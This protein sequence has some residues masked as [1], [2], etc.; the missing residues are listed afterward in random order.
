[1]KR[2][3]NVMTATS[4]ALYIVPPFAAQAQDYP[5]AMVGDVQVICLPDDQ[6][7]CPDGAT[8]AI[9][10]SP[11]SCQADAEQTLGAQTGADQAAV[12]QAAADQAAAD[13]AAADQAAADQ[14]A[15]DQAAADQAAAD[16][17]A[18]DQAAADQAA[19]DQAAADQAAA[20]Q[21][22]AD[23]AA[24]D[25]AAADQA[26]ADQAASAPPELQT[27]N[28]GDVEVI[29]LP[30]A[31]TSCPD[32][33]VC[34]VLTAPDSCQADA[35]KMISDQAAADKA[36]SDQAAADQAAADQAAADQAAADKAA[37]DQAAA[38]QAA[39]DQ[40]AADKAASDQAAADKA[41]SDQAAADQAAAD[42][43]ASD[44]AAAQ[45]V[46]GPQIATVG[47]AQVV[48][49]PDAQTPCPDGAL[50][51]VLTSPD[52]CQADAEQAVAAQTDAAQQQAAGDQAAATEAAA[53][54]AQAIAAAEEAQKQAE[55][56]AAADPNIVPIEAPVPDPEAVNTLARVLQAPPASADTPD[57]PVAEV[58][59]AADPADL[60]TAPHA[61]A[62]PP[63]GVTVT[64]ETVT[65]SVTRSSSQEFHPAPVKVGHDKKSGL[66]DLEKVGLVA[67][68]ALV[69]GA[70]INDNRQQVVSNSG[71]RVV[72]RQDDGSYQVYKDDNALLRQ[73]GS[74][75]TTQTFR[76]GSTRVIV[77]REDGSQ[78]ATIRDASGR[79]LQRVAY[80]RKGRATVLI[81]DMQPETYV[82]VRDLPKPRPTHTTIQ[83]NDQDAAMRAALAAAD[84]EEIGRKFS[85]RQIR[86]IPQ[87]RELAP[88]INVNT[89]TFASG[90]AAI[91]PSEAQKLT[92]LGKFITDLIA[93]NP[94][95]VFLIE[96]HTDAVGSA[97]SNLALSDRRAESVAKALTEYFDVPPENLVVQGYGE[98]ELLVNSLGNERANRRVAVRIITALLQ[99]TAR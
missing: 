55:A 76:D 1:M 54:D 68:G 7:P 35:E 59:A 60:K 39:A 82:D 67:L 37:S 45:S 74:T 90:S 64:T 62:P 20:D 15:A 12:D 23:Q 84:A 83:L 53:Q 43:A 88:T 42:Q 46:A 5:T 36:A 4:L 77:E 44:Q 19:A 8:C 61:D 97:A 94:N 78:I 85:L 57:Q 22:A 51:A 38:D 9:L 28:V 18:A 73:P 95:E 14:A 91:D 34:T 29:C 41:A 33:S 92:K 3:I 96:G 81:D 66:S 2:L 65:T 16:Q 24:A 72:V 25:Q 69:I 21:A 56:A 89:I 47:D 52:S 11:D 58:V 48:C 31:Q 6:T 93:A 32:G 99:Q 17:A 75:V 27:A 40:A 10:T 86:T 63:E 30:D 50:C 49:L 13:Q 98:S 87:V 79:V 71:D 70:M 80:D 26:A